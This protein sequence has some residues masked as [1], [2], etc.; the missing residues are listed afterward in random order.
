LELFDAWL[1]FHKLSNVK[2]GYKTFAFVTDGY[3]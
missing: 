1:E 2:D 3:S